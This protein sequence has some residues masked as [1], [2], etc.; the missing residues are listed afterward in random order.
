MTIFLVA[1]NRFKIQIYTKIYRKQ[2]GEKNSFA[3]QNYRGSCISS[4]SD[5]VHY[6]FHWGYDTYV[7][8]DG[9]VDA[10]EWAGGFFSGI[11]G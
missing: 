9:L 6:S 2:K 8:A 11:F 3:H 10:G 5:S 4:D 1:K 7:V